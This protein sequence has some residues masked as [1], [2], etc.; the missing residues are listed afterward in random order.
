M[1]DIGLS[2]NSHKTQYT[3]CCRYI[4]QIIQKTHTYRLKSISKKLV[5]LSDSFSTYV[6]I[7]CKYDL[8][9]V[10]LGFQLRKTTVQFIIN[11][12]L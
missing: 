5:K 8:R 3:Q 4:Y 1:L 2:T 6:S 7:M 9:H 12:K 10:N 11:H